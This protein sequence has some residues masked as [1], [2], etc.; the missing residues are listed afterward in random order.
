MCDVL[1]SADVHIFNALNNIIHERSVI[2][3]AMIGLPAN[4]FTNPILEFSSPF[5]KQK[6]LWSGFYE[7]ILVP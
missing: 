3:K 4:L 2:R 5:I 7:G 1:G 6:C